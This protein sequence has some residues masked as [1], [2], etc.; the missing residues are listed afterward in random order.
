MYNASTHYYDVCDI[1]I[2][3]RITLSHLIFVVKHVLN[4]MDADYDNQ[5][6]ELTQVYKKYKNETESFEFD[7][8][9]TIKD[10]EDFK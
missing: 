10:I 5:Y 4:T 6:N 2:Y 7:Y 8:N 3:F 9:E 1:F